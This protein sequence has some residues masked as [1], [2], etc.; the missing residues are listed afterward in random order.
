M[1]IP[2]ISWSEEV[3]H[4]ILFVVNLEEKTYD[5]E[6]IPFLVVNKIHIKVHRISHI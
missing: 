5:N 3:N 6:S 1:L 2:L 4:L